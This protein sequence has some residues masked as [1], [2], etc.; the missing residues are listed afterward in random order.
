VES[1]YNETSKHIIREITNPTEA[2]I[3]ELVVIWELDDLAR[4]NP[5]H[6]A[7]DKLPRHNPREIALEGSDVHRP[8]FVGL[9]V[10]RGDERHGLEMAFEVSR[11]EQVRGGNDDHGCRGEAVHLSVT[12]IAR[13]NRA[14]HLLIAGGVG[15]NKSAPQLVAAGANQ[16]FRGTF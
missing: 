7:L 12:L 13:I 1:P 14:L 15:E 9:G 8:S 11:W 3:N 4:V 2:I 10:V 6:G 16:I 5:T